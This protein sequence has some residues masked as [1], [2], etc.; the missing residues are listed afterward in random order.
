MS[1]TVAGDTQLEGTRVAP[2]P[3]SVDV[4]A[5]AG[6]RGVFF[7]RRVAFSWTENSHFAATEQLKHLGVTDLRCIHDTYNESL[8]T[9]ARTT[10]CFDLVPHLLPKRPT[11][12]ALV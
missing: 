3:W 4:P 9:A 1:D 11:I 5:P 8:T 12:W 2:T 7:N 6:P 10:C